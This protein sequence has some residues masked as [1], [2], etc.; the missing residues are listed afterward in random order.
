MEWYRYGIWYIGGVINPHVDEVIGGGVEVIGDFFSRLVLS[1]LERVHMVGIW[2][3]WSWDALVRVSTVNTHL[4]TDV[5]NSLLPAFS[6]K[7]PKS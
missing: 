1:M 5:R 3:V 2:S 4:Q 7:Q 6:V